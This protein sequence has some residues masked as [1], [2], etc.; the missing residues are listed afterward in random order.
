MLNHNLLSVASRAAVWACD[1]T[2]YRRTIKTPPVQKE[3]LTKNLRFVYC[4]C[5]ELYD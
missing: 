2:R 4:L 3:I 5:L 1:I